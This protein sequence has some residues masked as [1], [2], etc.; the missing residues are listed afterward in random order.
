MRAP[1]QSE[2]LPRSILAAILLCF[3]LSGAAG[4]VYQVAW[5]KALGLVFG[6]TAYALA[7][8]LAVFMGGLALGSA[9]LGRWSERVRRP[10]ALY[11]W[12]ELGVAAAGAVSLAGLAGVRALYLASH[13]WAGES[14]VAQVALR[15]L[16]SALVL[17]LPTFLM[18]GTLPILVRG[19]TRSSAELGQ[20]VSRLYWINTAGAVVGTLAAGFLLLPTF[21]LKLTVATAVGLNI[22][23]GGIAL[24]LGRSI[25]AQQMP[26]TAEASASSARAAD[27]HLRL[28]LGGFALVG[29]TAMAYEIAWSRLLATILGSSTY[30]FTLMLATFLAGIVLGSMLFERWLAPGRQ[31]SLGTFAAT[32]TATALAALAFLIFFQQLPEVVPPI[33]RSTGRSFGGLVLAQF[34]TSAL[35][36][37]P[38]AVAFGFNFPV[39]TLL[40][41][42][43]PHSSTG[44]A[45]AVGRAYAFNTLGAI[46]GATAAGFWLLPVVGSFRLV[47][48]AAAANLLLAVLLHWKRAPRRIPTLALNAILLG[49]V[50]G[51]AVSGAFYNRSLAVFGTVLYWDLYKGGMTLAEMAATTEILFVEDGLNASISVARTEDYLAIRTNGKVDAS[52]NDRVTQL[53]V[54]HLGALFHPSPRRVLV[55][56]FGSGMTV[57]AVARYAEVERID[58]VEIEP[59][60]IR[61]APYLESLHRGVLRDPRLRI[62]LDDGRN[63]LLTTRERYDLIISEPSNP[64]IAGVATLFTDDFYREA[65]AR[66]APGGLFVQW[67]QGYSL[68]PEDLRM[69]LGTFVPHFPRVTLW[70][71]EPTDFILLGE[72][73]PRPLSFDRLRTLWNNAALREDFQE[74]G[75]RRPEGL[76][77]FHRLD[78][79]DLRRFAGGTR[80]NTDDLTLLEYRAPRALLA[81]RLE[82]TNRNQVRQQRTAP[83]SS[84]LRIDDG[85]ATLVAAAETMLN[86]EEFREAEDFLAAVSPAPAT[87]RLELARG[88]L[89]LAR[90][91][92]PAAEA[93]YQSA[94]RL[95]TAAV[96]AVWGLAEVARRRMKFDTAELLLRQAIAR[97]PKSLSALDGLMRLE[98]SR[99]RWRQAAIWQARRIAADPKPAAPAYSALG[100]LLLRAG[101]FERA[102]RAFFEALD[103]DPYSYAAHRNLG[104]LYHRIGQWPPAIEHLEFVVRYHPEVDPNVYTELAEG[105][106]ATGSIRQAAAVLRKG[107]RIFPDRS[108]TFWQ[109]APAR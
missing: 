63:F 16:G 36:M 61:A 84:I 35:A 103:R 23:A 91:K 55:I 54:G 97:D 21:G 106:R 43:Q 93:A 41:A 56:G 3:F 64:W 67:V 50:L 46:A 82:D 30:A 44:Y 22:L 105:Y 88:R 76:A 59:A 20:R 87:A 28:L 100:E 72:I 77:A 65:R 32:Q 47:A 5:G 70:R 40:I 68:F 108:N 85:D 17:L 69:V 83:L 49:G 94:L 13:P 26:V 109:P 98:R 57:S 9:V 48:L 27:P 42:G 92:F 71:G 89:A 6:N 86:L 25:Q 31:V 90:S 45:A 37:L 33:L 95:D 101:D 24:W 10:V 51:I 60:V 73:E 79:A 74:L 18:G 2:S 78:D 38:A 29:A 12:V 107:R 104:E 19:L 15:F 53:L 14:P 96:D 39:A 1:V 34:V 52:N 66:L 58:C 8:V 62:V 11:G 81:P 99:E 75:L 102:E 7:T 80:R 4:L